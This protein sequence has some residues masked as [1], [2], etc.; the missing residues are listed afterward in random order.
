MKKKLLLIGGGVIAT[1]YKDGLIGSPNFRL[2]ALAD[3]N[4]SCAARSLLDVPFYTD[5]VDA[6]AIGIDVALISTSTSTHYDIASDLLDRGIDVITEKPMCVSYDKIVELFE[7][8]KHKN[9]HLGC[10]FHW[11]YADEVLFVKQHLTD[12]GKITSITV[13][14][15]DDYAATADGS[16]DITRRGLCGAWLDSGINVLSYISQL[17]DVSNYTLV[18]EDHELDPSTN[19]QK[20]AHRN[21]LFGKVTADITIDW[22][23]PSRDKTSQIVCERGVIDIN[24]SQQTVSLNGKVIYSNPLD[25]R[26]GGHYV[27][28]FCDYRLDGAQRKR[29]LLLHKILFEGGVS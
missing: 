11:M 5:Y 29:T 23:T 2:V 9:A 13:N 25:D 10:I 12:F 24:H 22:R 4:P 17:I 1:H 15:C 6:L 26:L 18:R 19:Q 7:L 28:T 16:I 14:I 8:A 3:I 20:Y 21:Y 27:N